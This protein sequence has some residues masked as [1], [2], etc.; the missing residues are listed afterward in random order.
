M[1]GATV[2]Y[3]VRRVLKALVPIEWLQD[4]D[5][6]LKEYVHVNSGI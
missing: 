1:K 6:K 2:A 4:F 5:T 3:E